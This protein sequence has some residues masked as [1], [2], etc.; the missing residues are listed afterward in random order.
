MQCRSTALHRDSTPQ[1]GPH[2]CDEETSDE[3]KYSTNI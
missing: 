3:E 2:Q 1:R